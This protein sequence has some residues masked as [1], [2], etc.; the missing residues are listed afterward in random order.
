M[1][2]VFAPLIAAF[3]LSPF[4]ATF[5]SIRLVLVAEVTILLLLALL[6]FIKMLFFILL[7]VFLV[8]EFLIVLV[9]L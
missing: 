1:V 6:L 2:T 3:L 7:V 4:L 8:V 5:N 9:G